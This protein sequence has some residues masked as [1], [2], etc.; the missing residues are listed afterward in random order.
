[1]DSREWKSAVDELFNPASD[2]V[3]LLSSMCSTHQG[4]GSQTM[5]LDGVSISA[6]AAL[7]GLYATTQA[8]LG[9][10]LTAIRNNRNMAA[11]RG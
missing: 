6:L 7:L 5:F 8:V 2:H 1:M 9:S 4:A 3:G 11:I 10:Y